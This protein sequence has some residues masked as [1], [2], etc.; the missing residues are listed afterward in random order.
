MRDFEFRQV[1][2]GPIAVEGIGVKVSC[3][4]F[5][6]IGTESCEKAMPAGRV[7]KAS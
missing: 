3:A 7:T 1:G 6:P 4:P 5:S 2:Q